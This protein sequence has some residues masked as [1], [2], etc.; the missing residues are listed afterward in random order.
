MTGG[1]QPPA[2]SSSTTSARP[3][4]TAGSG[5]SEASTSA[6]TWTS[7]GTAGDETSDPTGVGTG[8]ITDPDG[9][10][11]LCFVPTHGKA[12]YSTAC[13]YLGQDCP[14]GEVCKP[15]DNCVV[16]TWSQPVC[17]PAVPGAD[18]QHGE[19][20]VVE[21][22]PFSGLDTC[23]ANGVCIDVD[24]LTLEGRCAAYCSSD[25][26]CVDP[27]D[28][29]FRGNGGWLPVCLPGCSPL[30]GDCPQGQGCYPGTDDDFV[31]I[32][33]GAPMYNNPE[34]LHPACPA[35]SFMADQQLADLCPDEGPCC[36][37]FCDLTAPNCDDGSTC[38]GYFDELDGVDPAF[39][40]VG[41]C[42]P[43]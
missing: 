6:S 38:V 19:P 5:T 1:E 42:E 13:S 10:S 15:T 16:G 43:S 33:E 40:D 25:V 30:L 12:V 9:G 22:G 20:C 32:T 31:C 27:D 8:F 18:G 21:E 41:Y 26:A 2:P 4:T 14:R 37:W 39:H 11:S 28:A 23:A 3:E 34:V 7:T 29:C 36:A 35:G 17:V 24:P